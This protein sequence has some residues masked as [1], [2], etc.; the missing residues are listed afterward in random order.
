MTDGRKLVTRTMRN[1]ETI[2]VRLAEPGEVRITQHGGRA[3]WVLDVPDGAEIERH[4]L[5]T[6]NTDDLES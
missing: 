6:P 4:L 3:V 1:S 2:A 5:D